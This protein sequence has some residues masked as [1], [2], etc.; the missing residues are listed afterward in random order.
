MTG[1][2][3]GS[4][5]VLVY[6]DSAIFSGAES[7]LCE[8]VSGLASGGGFELMVAAPA[9][10]A[11]LTGRLTDAAGVESALAVPAQAL[12]LA[13]FDLYDPRRIRAV[14]KALSGV[15]ADVM[16]L[17]LPS[18]EYGATP[19]LAKRDPAIPVV[20]FMHV[21]GTM[22][23]L[24]FRLG[25]I[26]EGL[27]RRAVSRLDSVCLLSG[28][29]ARAYPRQWPA[30]ESTEINVVRMPK[31]TV[32]AID[33]GQARQ[34]FGLPP[35]RPVV[36]MAGRLT[37]KQKGQDTL[38]EAA[39]SL[40][41]DRPE[42][43][44]VVA[45]DGQ[46]RAKVEGLIAAAGLEDNFSM[47]GQVS[48]MSAFLSAIDLI[49]IPSRFEGL[50]LIA[51]EALTVGVPGVATSVDGLCDAWPA[52]WRVEPGDPTALAD[53]L[54]HLLDTESAARQHFISSGRD[55]IK[56]LTSTDA[57]ADVAACLERAVAR[58]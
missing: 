6:A 46:D 53:A 24:G 50:P 57:A 35:D 55:R 20:G 9:E 25:R 19:L 43:L 1:R 32:K 11:E 48:D 12:P 18:A 45:G 2:T 7:L 31:P 56:Q 17:N 22:G 33:R 40:V 36:G 29:A 28:Q 58:D 26:R 51:L 52:E 38:V 8:V 4:A 47:L 13:A 23:D 21:S 16:L 27:A 15:V 49:A 34:G 14:R 44:F 5:R 54:G 30:D 3:Q 42:L 10:N 41:A 37:I 39:R